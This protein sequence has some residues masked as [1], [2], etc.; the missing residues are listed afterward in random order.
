M[1][2]LFSTRVKIIL[3]A[4]V[5]LSIAL[6]IFSGITNTTVVDLAVGGVLAPFRAAAT[7]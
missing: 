1:R 7:T 3:A 2:N 5:L 6:S 4:A